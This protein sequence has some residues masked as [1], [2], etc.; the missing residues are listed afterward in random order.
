MDT[1][2]QI[3]I[4]KLE[5]EG[6]RITQPRRAVV[7]ALTERP[8]SVQEIYTRTKQNSGSID[9]ASIY[10]TLDILLQAGI[11]RMIETGERGRSYELVNEHNHHHHLICNICGSI[12]DVKLDEVG[13]LQEL[14]KRTHFSIDHHHIE[15]FGA[16][17]KCQKDR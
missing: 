13:M 1:T 9:L 8:L 3:V 15:F 17:Y 4:E 11:V 7:S 6:Y 10:R 2:E 5:H 12:E 16:C 14:K